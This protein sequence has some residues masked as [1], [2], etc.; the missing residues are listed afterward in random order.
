MKKGFTLAEVLV[1][2]VVVGFIMAMSVK[3]INIVRASYTALG[4]F[5]NENINLIVKMLMIDDTSSAFSKSNTSRMYCFTKNANGLIEK[6]SVFKP[7][8]E[9]DDKT[10]VPEC[11]KLG[12]IK[13]TPSNI[14]CKNVVDITNTTGRYDCENLYEPQIN[15]TGEP[16]IW[17]LVPDKPNFV[18]TNGQRYYI[19]KRTKINAISTNFGFRLIGVDLNGSAGPNKSLG[20]NP[21][22][23]IITFMIFDNGEVYPLGV[24]A[25]NITVNYAQNKTLQ[26]ITSRIKGYY[27]EDG[28]SVYIPNTTR[29][30]T[31]QNTIYTYREAFCS[32]RGSSPITYTNYCAG[33]LPHQLCPYSGDPQMFDLC[34]QENIK[35]MFRFNFK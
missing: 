26:Y 8:I 14:F 20:D 34:I 9:P 18:V 17:A 30:A 1:S 10:V 15:A 6:H 27:F 33:I 35:P 32:S 2:L 29:D 12:N 16:Y 3:S 23:D 22:P 5:A 11:S 28:E 7:D 21:P 31:N 25:D 4:Y 24:A 13:G 19:S